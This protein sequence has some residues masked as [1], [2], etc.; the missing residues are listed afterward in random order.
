MGA[1]CLGLES[2]LFS[3]TSHYG[4]PLLAGSNLYLFFFCHNKTVIISGLDG[5]ESAYDAGDLG[6]IPGSER[7][8]GEGNGYPL[9]YSCLENP[10]ERG[11]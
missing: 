5:K 9:Q 11:A 10:K 3:R 6:S 1:S 8:P 4:S 7:S 2:G